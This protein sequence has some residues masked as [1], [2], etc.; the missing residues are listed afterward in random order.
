MPRKVWEA[1]DGSKTYIGIGVMFAVA[2]L[3]PGNPA[4]DIIPATM[5][6]MLELI[7]RSIFGVGIVA[8]ADKLISA[9]R[10]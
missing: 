1:F 8:K 9:F 2:W 3:G 5:V 4:P 7:G 10:K 6:P